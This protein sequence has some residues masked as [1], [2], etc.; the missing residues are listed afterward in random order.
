LAS[1]KALLSSLKI[2]TRQF[3]DRIDFSSDTCDVA[4]KAEMLTFNSKLTQN[5]TNEEILNIF[6]NGLNSKSVTSNFYTKIL[7]NFNLNN[8]KAENTISFKLLETLEKNITHISM[9]EIQKQF[10]KFLIGTLKKELK[11]KFKNEFDEL[12]VQKK[13]I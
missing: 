4:L 13:T 12:T 7:H 6:E 5:V 3:T 10:Y 1:L 9:K 8:N 2:K 11:S